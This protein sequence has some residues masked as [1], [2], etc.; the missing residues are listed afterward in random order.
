MFEDETTKER[1]EELQQQR[2]DRILSVLRIE[3]TTPDPS[4][5]VLWAA[6]AVRQ[7]ERRAAAWALLQV[8]GKRGYSE[9]MTKWLEREYPR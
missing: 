4:K 8:T 2:L 5:M 6:E 9:E 7:A 3:I 1:F